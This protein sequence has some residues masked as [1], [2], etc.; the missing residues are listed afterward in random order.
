MRSSMTTRATVLLMALALAASAVGPVAAQG[1]GDPRFEE[2]ENRWV[3]GNEEITVWFQG[4]K[5]LLKVMST[6]DANTSYEFHALR[7]AEF[8]DE[9]DD[10]AYDEDEAVAFMNLAQGADW[11]VS[12]ESDGD[13]LLVNL[14]L[15]SDIRARGPSLDDAPIVGEDREGTVSLVF[16][17]VGTEQEVQVGHN[18]TRTL[19]PGEVKFDLIVSSW[20]WSDNE[21]SQL[22]LVANVPR[23]N[24]TNVTHMD[25]EQTVEMSQNGTSQGSVNWEPT[26]TVWTGNATQTVDVVPTVKDKESGENGTVQ[27]AWA[28]NATGFDRLVHDPTMETASSEDDGSDDDG[29]LGGATDDVPATGALGALAI[30]G[31][32]ALAMARR[33][34]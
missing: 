28:Y 30:L 10:G 26:A 32:A 12:T 16:H 14:T 29:G 20:D 18:T 11:N 17:V 1:D 34:N 15:T 8:V 9:D 7:V 24:G 33:R 23:G 4:K 19:Q 22:A 5:P 21:D 3:L 31:A 6:D 27:V 25:G 13:R 2:S